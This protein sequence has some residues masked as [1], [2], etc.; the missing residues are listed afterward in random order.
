MKKKLL[1]I[2]GVLCL[3]NSMHVAAQTP[4][5]KNK[6]AS[7]EARAKDLLQRMTVDEKI[8]QM[9]CR[10]NTKNLFINADG[11]F[12]SAKATAL[13]KNG[14]GEIA[15]IN[16]LPGTQTKGRHPKDAA[17][18]YNAVQHFFIEHT[19]LGIP[20]MVHEEGLHGQQ[21]QDATNFPVPMALAS[22]WDENMLTDIYSNVAAEIRARGAQQVLAPV[23]DVVRDPRWGRT[24]ET[25]GEDPYLIS[26]LAVAEIKGFQGNELYLP[27]DKV[28]VTLK[29][30]GVHGQSEGGENT[31][32]SN[33]DERTAMET[34]FAPFKACIMQ[35]KPMNIMPCYNELF[36]LPVHGNKKLLTDLLRDKWGFDGV[37]V[38]DYGGISD[39][40]ALHKIA[41]DLKAAALL[42]FNAGVDI[43]TPDPTAYVYIKELYEE[44]KITEAQIDEHVLRI[45][46][47]KFRTGLFDHP[48]VDANAADSI[49]GNKAKRALAYKA[50]TESMVLLKN[51]DHFLPLDKNKIKTI[52]FIGPNAD[53]AL[54]GGYSGDPRVR[55]S[56]L[57][58]LKEKYGNDIKILYSEG[59]TLTDK[60]DWFADTIH[61]VKNDPQKIKDAVAIAKQ[62]DVVV[63][64]V[65][66]NESMRREGWSSDHLGDLPT[67]NLLNGQ[68]DLIDSVTA[69]GK[70]VCAFV[71]SGA[72]L[73]LTPLI[74]KVPAI[75]Q[76]WYLGQEGGYAMIDALF[77][78]SNPSGKLPISVPRGAGYLPDYYN[79]KPSSRRGYN[80]GFDV[81]P[82]YPFG[83]GLSYTNFRYDSVHLSSSKMNMQDSVIVS[84]DV[85]NTGAMDGDE[86]V[87]LYIYANYP[88]ATRP[89]QELKD[90]KRIHLA[91]GEKQTVSFTI[92]KET[93]AYYNA[94][95]QWVT[96]PGAYTIMVGSSS[97][98][99]REVLLQV[100]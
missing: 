88:T 21:T 40:H 75:M 97:K 22:S 57:Q 34:F 74:N 44:K 20:V 50:A 33:I 93:L 56:P 47:N 68:T 61:L 32:P 79:Y 60:N 58:A 82:L 89:V 99:Y 3:F 14:L 19:R 48:Y 76:C 45:L 71:N 51:E 86:V 23:V 16:E 5:Y 43:E 69:T 13:L 52:A 4:L 37:F 59:V 77:G 84:V 65:G 25:L 55:I 67:L 73:N 18:L 11:N 62:A 42:A 24:E 7:P 92:N 31:A 81:S 6:K 64:F 72:P 94:E 80:L 26:R 95:I 98:E 27:S 78:N 66:E 91:K 15:R 53:K 8:A 10:W 35:A 30:F 41:P 28:A 12:D 46:V 2:S 9:Q 17:A 49:V 38:S 39:I 29:H 96:E 87:Q 54:L 70:P 36:G 1:L 100:Q 63:L 83:Y 90:F 85:T